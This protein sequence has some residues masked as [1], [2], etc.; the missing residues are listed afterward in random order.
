[1]T[2]APLGRARRKRKPQPDHVCMTPGCG[3][4]IARWKW[5]CD[6]CFAQLP[7]DRK[8]EICGARAQREPHRVFGL[9]RGAGEWLAARRIKMT[10]GGL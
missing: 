3:A 9:S 5:L 2:F 6:S 10:E 8:K 4:K 7:F 1:M